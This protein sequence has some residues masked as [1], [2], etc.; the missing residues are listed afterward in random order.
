MWRRAEYSDGSQVSGTVDLIDA[1]DD[2]I[3]DFVPT[4]EYP[5]HR[6]HFDE[7]RAIEAL[8]PTTVDQI[9]ACTILPWF[10]SFVEELV[11]NSLDAGATK[12]H[13]EINFLEFSVR[14][15]DNGSQAVTVA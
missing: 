12:I 6:R 1:E 11:F 10:H 4:I 15:V 3:N 8:P 7:S 13:V 14:V 9:R 5:H 2:S